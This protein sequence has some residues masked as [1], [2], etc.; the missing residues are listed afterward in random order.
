MFKPIE[1]HLPVV[2][3]TNDYA[4]ELLSTY[5]YVLVSA[6]HQTAGR[7]RKSREWIGDYG[8]N[9]YMSIATKHSHSLST[10]DLS[11]YMWRGALAVV[12]ALRK[13]SSDV[14]FRIKY[15]ND[16]QANVD[17]QWS[18]ISGILIEHE[19]HG[20]VCVNTVV[21]IGVNVDQTV[22][23][24]NIG[25]LCTSLKCLGVSATSEEILSDTD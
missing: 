20:S 3:S 11:S 19:F 18:K 8:S 2:T 9:V 16:I 21:G 1:F 23:P 25:Q 5:P 22:F 15:P 13:A 6:L 7:G 12:G 14:S 4:K 10:E 24:E 17:G